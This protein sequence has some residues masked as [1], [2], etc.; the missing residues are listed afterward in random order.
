MGKA[1]AN[2]TVL[3]FCLT[4]KIQNSTYRY[5]QNRK[6]VA[7]VYFDRQRVT[8]MLCSEHS[9]S[10]WCEHVVALI[11]HRMNNPEKVKYRLPVSD[12]VHLLSE[13]EQKQFIN[14]LL[15]HRPLETLAF[16]QETLDKILK[17]KDSNRVSSQC[18]SLH[19]TLV[20]NVPDPT[21]GGAVDA[22]GLWNVDENDVRQISQEFFRNDS[23]LCVSP[24]VDQYREKS[25][26]WDTILKRA[27]NESE[28]SISSIFG[29][30]GYICDINEFVCL[31]AC[32]PVSQ[33]EHFETKNI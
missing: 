28:T 3:G 16:A 27:T 4:G 29:R 26:S 17:M 21:A 9:D 1:T 10:N 8:S 7:T 22:E 2:L 13:S 31:H 12:S 11:F 18:E 20:V 23:A 32:C 5:N 19:N 30:H 6:T 33:F 25:E 15:A 14:I 24:L